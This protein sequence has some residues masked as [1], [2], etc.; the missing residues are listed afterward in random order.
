MSGAAKG[1]GRARYSAASTR[2]S[3]RKRGAKRAEGKVET[4]YRQRRR[5]SAAGPL[6]RLR[7][8][9]IGKLISN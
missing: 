4:T 2:A 7:P 9:P 1:T 5:L 6:A 3:L 8:T